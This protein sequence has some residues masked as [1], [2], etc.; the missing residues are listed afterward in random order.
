MFTSDYISARSI[1]IEEEE[2]SQEGRKE[3]Q[4]FTLGGNSTSVGVRF[5]GYAWREVK[6]QGRET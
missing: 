2:A 3:K 4:H 1:A 6:S 5:V